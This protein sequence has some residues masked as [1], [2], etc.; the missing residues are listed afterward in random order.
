MTDQTALSIVDF[1]NARLAEDAEAAQAA[2]GGEWTFKETYWLD[3]NWAIE[4]ADE[5]TVFRAVNLW[6][7][8][9]ASHVARHD[10]ARVLREIAAKRAIIDV[11]QIAEQTHDILGD[12]FIALDRAVRTLADI[13]ADH[14]EYN[15]EW[16]VA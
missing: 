2:D 9:A 7:M 1:L 10:P 6:S 5:D 16:A 3:Y 8:P 12:G 4:N 13:Y 14:A 15:R 11:W